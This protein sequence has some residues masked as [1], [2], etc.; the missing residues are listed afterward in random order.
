MGKRKGSALPP[1]PWLLALLALGAWGMA[2]WTGWEG[3]KAASVERAALNLT[4]TM[5]VPPGLERP[6]MLAG[7]AVALTMLAMTAANLRRNRRLKRAARA[8]ADADTGAGVRT[9]PESPAAPGPAP[10]PKPGNG[11]LHIPPYDPEMAD[12][13]GPGSGAGAAV[14]REVLA[15]VRTGEGGGAYAARR[16]GA[17]GAGAFAALDSGGLKRPLAG[18]GVPE[19]LAGPKPVKKESPLRGRQDAAAAAGILSAVQAELVKAPPKPRGFGAA[20]DSAELFARAD[21][22]LGGGPGR[23][24]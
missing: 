5:A 7:L 21:A 3:L 10:V 4:G 12:G 15:P 13:S 17:D 24:G 8:G 23:G 18:R 22:A 2:G 20:P 1:A 6:A 16:D 19:K 11:V 9:P 14:M